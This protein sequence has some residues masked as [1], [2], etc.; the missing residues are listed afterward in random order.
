MAEN[1]VKALAEQL[2]LLNERITM[3]PGAMQAPS[4]PVN[5]GF[6]QSVDRFEESIKPGVKIWKFGKWIA[7]LALTI[8]GVTMAYGEFMAGNATKSDLAAHIEADFNPVQTKV[9]TIE[10]G[11][12]VLLTEKQHERKIKRLERQ[13]SKHQTKFEQLMADHRNARA[14]NVWSKKP[15]ESDR[16][17]DLESE[18]EDLLNT[19]VRIP[20]QL[21]ATLAPGGESKKK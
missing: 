5:G 13:I 16:L 3:V 4:Y 21:D 14:R 20:I 7:G 17:I 2:R 15:T 11:V 12:N 10:H 1:D 19:P 6:G 9:E 18:L 8:V